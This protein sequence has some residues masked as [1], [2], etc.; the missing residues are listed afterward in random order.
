MYTRDRLRLTGGAIVGAAV[1]PTTVVHGQEPGNAQ[2]IVEQ[3]ET[4]RVGQDVLRPE[5]MR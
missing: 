4:A 5:V 1:S 2:G 3:P